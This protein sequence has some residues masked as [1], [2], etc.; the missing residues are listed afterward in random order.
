MVRTT[1]FVALA[2]A[3]IALAAGCSS[4][5]G[6]SSSTLCSDVKSL[7]SATQQLKQVDVVKDGTSSLQTAL[8]NVKQS[9]AKVHDA[10]KDEFKPQ[11][12]ALQSALTSLASALKNIPANGLAPVQQAAQSV[13]TANTELQDAIKSKDCK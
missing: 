8:D 2:C 5:G 4:S 10:A 13:Q 1:S 7:Q 6:N 12:D 11:S 3:A 9:A